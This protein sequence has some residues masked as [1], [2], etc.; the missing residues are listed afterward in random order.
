[1]KNPGSTRLGRVIRHLDTGG[2]LSRRNHRVKGLLILDRLTRWQLTAGEVDNPSSLTDSASLANCFKNVTNY[3][4]VGASCIALAILISGCGGSSTGSGDSDRIVEGVNL[5]ELLRPPT[6]S[7]R[8]EVMNEWASRTH[9][10]SNVNVVVENPV[11][12]GTTAATVSIISHSV[13]S[14]TH[15]GAL[16]AP[17]NAVPGSLPLFVYLHGGDEGVDVSEL[18]SVISIGLGSS[19]DNYAYLVPS[20]RAEELRYNG[21]T[22]SSTGDPSPWDRDVDDAQSLLDVAIFLLPAADPERIAVVGVSRGACVGMLMGI[23]DERV[24]LVIEFFGPTDFFSVWSEDIFADALRGTLRPL[25]GL[26]TLYQDV[27]QP[28]KAGTLTFSQVRQQILRRSPAH[29]VSLLPPTQAHHGTADNVVPVS[30]AQALRAAF[31][32][33]GLSAPDYNVYLYAGGGHNPLSLSGSLERARGFLQRLSMPALAGAPNS[34][35]YE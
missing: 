35:T 25:P 34:T 5:T 14:V 32:S 19:Q 11:M 8:Q 29:F 12:L 16:L 26:E 9:G 21:V 24:D 22:Y 3:V 10:A 6:A 18:L 2:V 17:N 31:T 20:F 15:F 23:R 1:M 4:G 30:E 13:G 33:A 27:V 28:L 7:E